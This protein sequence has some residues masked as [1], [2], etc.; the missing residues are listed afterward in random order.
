M[1]PEYVLGELHADQLPPSRLH[2]NLEP[3]SFEENEKLAE[4]E[5]V[6]AAGALLIVV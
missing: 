3:V 6:V 4:V 5:V 2:A 1:R